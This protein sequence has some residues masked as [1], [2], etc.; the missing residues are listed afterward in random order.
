MNDMMWKAPIMPE[1]PPRADAADRPGRELRIG[2]AII[3]LFFFGLLG[4]AALTPLDAGAY[5]QGVVAVSGSRQAVQHREGGIVTALHVVEG[6]TVAKGEA[7]LK[8]S[9]S[10]LVATERGL[11]GEVI[12]LLAQRA[13]LVAEQGGLQ[14]MAEPAEFA[15]LAPE[16]RTLAADALRGQRQLFQARRSSVQTQRSVLNQRMRQHSEQINGYAYQMRSNKE[17]Q[18]LIGDELGGLR[19]LLPKGFISINRVRAMERAA[20]ELDGTYGAYRSDIARSSEAIGEAQM[21]IVAL[22]KQVLEEVATQMREGQVRLDEL[23]PKLVALREQLSRSTVRAPASGRVVGLKVFTVGGVVAAGDTL[24]EIV[25]Q[26][27]ALVI[28]GK[29][30]PTDADDL[31]PGMETQ[32]RFTAL[33]ERNLPILVGRISKVSA[34]SFEDPRT[35]QR[36]FKIELVVPPSERDKL[37]KVRQDGGLRAGLPV[38]IIIPLR[39]RTALSYLVEPLAQVLWLAGREN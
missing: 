23:Q 3:A 25:P 31:T 12:A 28:E 15:S 7:L 24:M 30:S 29:A 26:D 2:V 17:Q 37:R 22:D 10:E 8:I 6:Q 35:G 34:D 33:Q 9:A 21:Q 11:T 13:R 16:N 14:M 1:T 32:I 39:K 4:W 27:R 18:R 20:A 19:A 36:F 5:A 38:D